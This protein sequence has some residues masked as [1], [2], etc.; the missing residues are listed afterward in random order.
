MKIKPLYLIVSGI[1]FVSFFTLAN[2]HFLRHNLK[3]EYPEITLGSSYRLVK[4]RKTIS[5][6]CN[7]LTLWPNLF[8]TASFMHFQNQEANSTINLRRNCWLF[9]Q[10]YSQELKSAIR[11]IILKSGL[12]ISELEIYWPRR[13]KNFSQSLSQPNKFRIRGKTL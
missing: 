3:R 8:F 13:R 6:S 1:P 2:T 11:R 10:K 12:W 7:I 4:K 5:F 9:F